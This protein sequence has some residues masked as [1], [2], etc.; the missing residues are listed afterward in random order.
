[1]PSQEITKKILDN[2]YWSAFGTGANVDPNFVQ[3]PIDGQP[4]AQAREQVDK[5]DQT[6]QNEK[7]QAA[8]S[9]CG[10]LCQM[11]RP[12]KALANMTE[13]MSYAIPVLVVGVAGSILYVFVAKGRQ[14]DVNRL[15]MENQK[16]IREIGPGVAAAVVRK[17]M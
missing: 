5:M 6:A 1:M 11:G 17:G 13:I 10:F 2:L 3:P 12:F 9:E 8:D 15:A 7:D 14:L 4:S 16:T